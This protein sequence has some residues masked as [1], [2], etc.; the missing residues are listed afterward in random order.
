MLLFKAGQ[1][2]KEQLEVPGPD[3][4]HGRRQGE[5]LIDGL[6]TFSSSSVLEAAKFV[7]SR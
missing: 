6:M 5:A 7:F 3:E 1:I 2:T 4:E